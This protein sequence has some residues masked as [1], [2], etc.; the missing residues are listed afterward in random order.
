MSKLDNP[1]I[2]KIKDFFATATNLD[3]GEIVIVMEC[4]EKG[5]LS[6]VLK[7][8]CKLCSSMMNFFLI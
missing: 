6:D 1:N 2:V 3:E 8:Q 7:T 5:S 4:A